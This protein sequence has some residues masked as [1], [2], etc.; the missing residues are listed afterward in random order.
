MDGPRLYILDGH[1]VV[2]VAEDFDLGRWLTEHFAERVV[3]K[4]NLPGGVEVSTVFLG[5]DHGP[6]E[7][8]PA[9]FE[10]KI[11]GGP[12]A[13]WTYRYTTWQDAA[14]GHQAVVEVLQAEASG[15]VDPSLPAGSVLRLGHCPPN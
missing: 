11:F 10:T 9:V 6:Q 7:K 8:L 3:A 1:K 12:H 15:P 14:A 5:L 2:P 4:T 13:D